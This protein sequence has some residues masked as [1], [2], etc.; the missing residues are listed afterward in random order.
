MGVRTKNISELKKE[1]HKN[2]WLF[3]FIL[4]ICNVILNIIFTI[5][6]LFTFDSYSRAIFILQISLIFSI[7]IVFQLASTMFIGGGLILLLLWLIIPLT[8]YYKLKKIKSVKIKSISMVNKNLRIKNRLK[9]IFYDPF[10]VYSTETYYE[11]FNVN[12]NLKLRNYNR[13]IDKEY[14]L[15][16]ILIWFFVLLFY[17]LSIITDYNKIFPIGLFLLNDEILIIGKNFSDYISFLGIINILCLSSYGKN[18]WD[19]FI[20]LIYNLKILKKEIKNITLINLIKRE[21]KNNLI[22]FIFTII[23]SIIIP[24]LLFIPLI[25]E[26]RIY[27]PILFLF[28]INPLIF[29]LIINYI[30]LD[31]IYYVSNKIKDEFNKDIKLKKRVKGIFIVNTIL[32]YF[33][34]IFTFL[35]TFIYYWLV[36]LRVYPLNNNFYFVIENFKVSFIIF[37][38]LLGSLTIMTYYNIK[39]KRK[40]LQNNIL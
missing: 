37:L 22:I 4:I 32:N 39:K 7:L 18:I 6:L 9:S 17:L 26:S 31:S 8:I 11:K 16:L 30:Y 21:S 15:R 10:D 12:K 34:V 14:Y 40:I 33:L 36:Y 20:P 19:I 29:Y 38:V 3:F 28:H 1:K 27:S 2:I 23:Y 13:F 35:L 5:F 25:L 24:V